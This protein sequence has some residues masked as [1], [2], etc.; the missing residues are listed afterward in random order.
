MSGTRLETTVPWFSD[1]VTKLHLDLSESLPIRVWEVSHPHRGRSMFDMHYGLELGIVFS[2]QLRRYY[3][4]WH[5]DLATGDVWFCGMWEPHGYE[6]LRV[7]CRMLS[8]AVLPQLL[9]R[10]HFEEALAYDW[11]APF[12]VEPSRRPRTP[13]RLKRYVCQLGEQIIKVAQNNTPADKVHLR[14]LVLQ[15]LLAARRDWSVPTKSAVTS[16]DSY[17]PIGKAIEEV[18]S[19]KRRVTIQGV[20]RRCGLSRNTFSRLFKTVMGLSFSDFSLRYRLHG[21]RSQ[22]VNSEDPIKT[23][24]HH[25]GF[26]DA[27]HFCRCFAKHFGSPPGMYRKCLQQ[28][29]LNRNLTS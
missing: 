24:A 16:R 20:A 29:G 1:E 23:I 7:P 9:A 28:K 27:C 13:R 25:W 15:V 8:I 17:A 3:R 21:A 10:A 14:L 26:T 22:L 19:G 5:A 18:F 4:R 6:I 12:A 11:L 2:G